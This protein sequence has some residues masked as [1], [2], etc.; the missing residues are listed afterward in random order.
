MIGSPSVTRRIASSNSPLDSRKKFPAS[1]WT[2][3][4]TQQVHRDTTG[5][6]INN[7]SIKNDYNLLYISGVEE[8][9]SL[10]DL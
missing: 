2:G 5:N 8:V 4:M 6:N 10:N 3:E 9:M 7:N 1:N